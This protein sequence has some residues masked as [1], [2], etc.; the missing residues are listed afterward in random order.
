MPIFA[1]IPETPHWLLQHRRPDDALASLQWLR[2]WVQP[3][4]V[5]KEFN[6]L[7]NYVRTSNACLPCQ[8]SGSQCS[9]RT[10]CLS[11]ATEL[12]NGNVLRPFGLVVMC[13]V[14]VQSNGIAAIKPFLV[15]VFQIFGVPMNANWA[16]VGAGLFWT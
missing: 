11:K 1:Q 2:G 13:F 15:Q 3:P 10:G 8:R 4:A 12:W 5:Q 7:I 14:I 6:D 16:S 9:H